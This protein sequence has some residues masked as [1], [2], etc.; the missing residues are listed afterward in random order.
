MVDTVKRE[1]NKSARVC[2]LSPRLWKG[3]T[4]QE[5]IND[6]VA[7]RGHGDA[8][9]AHTGG[10][11]KKRVTIFRNLAAEKGEMVTIDHAPGRRTASQYQVLNKGGGWITYMNLT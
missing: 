2:D 4:Y 9:K 10:S 8:G 7:R 6:A 11:V 1:F 3:K 5:L